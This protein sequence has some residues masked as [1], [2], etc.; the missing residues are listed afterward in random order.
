M[1]LNTYP[2]KKGSDLLRQALEKGAWRARHLHLAVN[3]I[4]DGT[5][6]VLAGGGDQ[7]FACLLSA[8][9]DIARLREGVH[10]WADCSGRI[11]WI[12]L[13][14]ASPATTLLLA[15]RATFLEDARTTR[16]Q[17]LSALLLVLVA[18]SASAALLIIHRL[19]SKPLADLLR[20]VRGFGTPEIPGPTA[21]PTSAGVLGEVALAFD[22]M[23]EQLHEKE[24]LLLREAQGKLVLE[25]RLG[26]IEKFATMGRVAGSF[27]WSLQSRAACGRP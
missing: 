17:Q 14:A 2:A 24:V 15:R 13:P 23:A 27:G 1:D 5:G 16:R 25:H 9:P 22:H 6:R 8:L 12:A 10:G 20:R 18:A 11:R 3:A 21:T 26:H 19:L 7:D 4:L